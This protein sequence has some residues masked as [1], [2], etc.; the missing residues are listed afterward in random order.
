MWGQKNSTLTICKSAETSGLILRTTLNSNTEKGPQK[1][2]VHGSTCNIYLEKFWFG[3]NLL[4]LLPEAGTFIWHCT[5]NVKSLHTQE[6]AQQLNSGH[7]QH[8][9]EP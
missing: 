8:D 4:Y 7:G 5:A 3:T 9:L 2:L 6:G 1:I